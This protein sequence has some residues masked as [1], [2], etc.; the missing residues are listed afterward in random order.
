MPNG[1]AI[2]TNRKARRDYFILEAFEAGIEL[3]GSEIKSIRKRHAS[4]SDSYATVEN[5]ELFLYNLHINPYEFARLE[6]V[7]PKRRRKLLMRK[8]EI[9]YIE[10]K[11]S[12]KGL[13][14]IPLRIYLKGRF[15]KVELALAKGKKFYDK[16]ETLKAKEAKRAMSRA[17]RK[18]R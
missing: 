8:N 3:K 2:V 15:V 12:T 14:L 9:R 5:N 10:G 13:T 11:R 18:K 7:D 1:E 16:R 4:L 17:L 6:E